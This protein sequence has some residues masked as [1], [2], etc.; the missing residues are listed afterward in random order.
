METAEKDR[1]LIYAKFRGP[2]PAKYKLPPTL[3]HGGHD[4]S[5]RASPAYTM[6]ARYDDPRF[7]MAKTPGPKYYSPSLTRHGL[8]GSPVYSIQGRHRERTLAFRTPGPGAYASERLF[9]PSEARAPAYSLAERTASR[10]VDLVPAP[11]AYSLPSTLGSHLPHRRSAPSF[12][13]SARR[14]VGGH[15]EDLARTPGPAR[16]DAAHASDLRPHRAPAWSLQSRSRLPGDNTQKP[17]PGAHRPETCVS[18]TTRRAPTFRMGVRHSDY[19]MPL[20]C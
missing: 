10:S 11:N 6:S 16:Y 18:V 9:S 13:V 15:A 3:G 14:S 19:V 5:K 17:G 2:G 4:V 8:E 7:P 20:I 12:S 1:P